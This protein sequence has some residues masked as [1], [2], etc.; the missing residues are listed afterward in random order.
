MDHAS[1]A[2]V[3]DPQETL[4]LMKRI[5]MREFLQQAK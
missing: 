3:F 4:A 2:S 5:M 1:P